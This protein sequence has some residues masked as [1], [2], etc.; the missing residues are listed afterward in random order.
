MSVAILPAIA[1][2][3]Q[4]KTSL[5]LRPS[6]FLG[7]R[8]LVM[9]LGLHGG[10]LSVARWLLK[11]GATVRV[12][13][14]KKKSQLAPTMA[15]LPKTRR[16]TFTLGAHRHA[17]FR[18][19]DMVVQNP[20]VP[21][22]SPYLV[23]ARR[24][25]ATVENE[26]TLF[27]KLVGRERIVGVTGTRGK[28]TTA[29]LSAAILKTVYPNT[30]LGGNI[31]TA[32]MF[33]VVDRVLSF[34]APV[35][36][37]LSSWHLE[38]LGEQRLSP[39]VAVVTN[40][41][42]DH[43]NR[44]RSMAAYAA[45][46]RQIVANQRD[47]DFVVLNWD[48]PWTRKLA[49]ACRGTVVACGATD[50]GKIPEVYGRRTLYWCEGRAR[51]RV[52]SRGDWQIPGAHNLSNILAAVA[53]SELFGVPAGAIR[54]ALRAFPGLPY[55]QQ[56][57][58]SVNRVRYVNDTTATTPEATIAALEAVGAGKRKNDRRLVLIA[59]G[60]D[61]GLPPESFAAL[62]RAIRASCKAVV[63]FS[64]R[65]SE[66]I[67][68]ELE[69]GNAVLSVVSNVQTMAEAVA[70]AQTFAEPGDTVLLSPACAS[71]G[72]FQHEFDRGDQFNVCVRS[73]Q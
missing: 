1:R 21:R 46:K 67:G 5:S 61:K 26:A 3:R 51:V 27:F 54:K 63:L 37:E 34:R 53:V 55:R 29:A 30:V 18:W 11:R 33:A 32:P 10:G 42:P 16:L 73:S 50:T 12:T 69:R 22:E 56:Y 57:V 64:G 25:N 38:N 9:G 4:A 41:M 19:A 13:D 23:T 59:G 62:A 7:A 65:G 24:A 45:A 48:N 72:L 6:D 47:G 39:H 2:R 66:R 36:L 58:G 60:S 17:D 35:V 68:F 14:L 31:A 8:V 40:V 49:A 71:F 20:G 43:L 70:A 15:R 28:S 44:Y 52:A